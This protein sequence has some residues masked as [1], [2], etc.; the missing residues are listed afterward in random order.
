MMLHSL[1][2]FVLFIHEEKIKDI[3]TT[4]KKDKIAVIS[5]YKKIFVFYTKLVL[6][7]IMNIYFPVSLISLFLQEQLYRIMENNASNYKHL[8]LSL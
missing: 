8:L 5:Y 4:T 1:C 6:R 2:L 3:P 7:S